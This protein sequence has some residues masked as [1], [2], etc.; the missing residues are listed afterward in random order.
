MGIS[1]RADAPPPVHPA[2]KTVRTS[3]STADARI[4]VVKPASRAR[5]IVNGSVLTRFA[6]GLAASHVIGSLV[7]NHARKNCSVAMSAL[8]SA[9]NPALRN[10]ECAI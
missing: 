3:A 6:D 8:V 1:A 9:G 5:S 7:N 10:A 4:P 2:K